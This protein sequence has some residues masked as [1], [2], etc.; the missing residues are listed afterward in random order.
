MNLNAGIIYDN[1]MDSIPV[2]MYGPV[3]EALLLERPE[4]I[5]GNEKKLASDHL[6]VVKADK[7]PQRP[8]IEPGVTIVC[9]GETINLAY[10]RDRCCIIQTKEEENFYNIFNLIQ[11]IYNKYEAWDGKLNEILNGNASVKEMAESSHQI[12]ENPIIVIDSN[13]HYVAFTGY[14]DQL[15]DESEAF[16]NRPD[17]NDNMQLPTLGQFLKFREPAMHVKEPL[18]INL[19]GSSTLDINLFDDGEYIGCLTIDYRSRPHRTSDIALGQHLAKLITLATHRSSTIMSNGKSTL[20]K[21]LRDIVDGSSIDSYQKRLLESAGLNKEYICVKMKFRNLAEQVPTGYICN[22]IEAKFSKSIAF[23]FDSSVVSF[24]GTDSIRDSGSKFLEGLNNTFSAFTEAI[25]I[26][27]GVSDSFTNLF[28]AKLYYE[29][30]CAALEN[31]SLIHPEKQYYNFQD[32][33][34]ME[35]VVNSLGELPLEMY[36]SD[37]M[38]RLVE[39]DRNSQVSYLETLRVYLEQNMS[40]TKTSSILYVHRSTLLE[41]LSRIERELDADI[42]DSNERLRLQILLKA[43]Q[44]HNMIQNNS[45]K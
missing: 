2:K 18:L 25:S 6:Y 11:G 5:L 21:I 14:T 7:L 19:L 43:I 37:G 39:H 3:N 42:K 4:F 17:D 8:V 32:Y 29:Q 22:L 9:V 44:I 27:L 23:E 12:F 30:T 35:M 33:A 40:I 31:G 13:F 1:L 10:Y 24:V 41:R 28:N 20:R 34:L 38:R 36:Y 15:G 26:R 45:F 16:V